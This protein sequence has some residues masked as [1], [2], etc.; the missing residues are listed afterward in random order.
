MITFKKYNSLIFP[1]L[2]LVSF[3]LHRHSTAILYWTYRAELTN[4]PGFRVNQ[5]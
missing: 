2:T 3:S 4:D 5:K 1:Y